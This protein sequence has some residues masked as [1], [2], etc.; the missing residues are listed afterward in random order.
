V[1]PCRIK[2]NR[3]STLHGPFSS[4][5]WE[6]PLEP[7]RSCRRTITHPISSL[8]NI[9]AGRRFRRHPSLSF[10]EDGHVWGAQITRQNGRQKGQ[11]GAARHRRSTTFVRRAWK[12]HASRVLRYHDGPGGRT[13]RHGHRD[14]ALYAES[15]FKRRLIFPD[16]RTQEI[17]GSDR[18]GAVG[19][20]RTRLPQNSINCR[21]A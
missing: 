8:S 17:D 5:T 3:I 4:V 14:Y 12:R 13:S 16:G 18:F 20:G 2:H 15:S 1:K 7:E 6:S 10:D 11:A 19:T 21:R 9:R